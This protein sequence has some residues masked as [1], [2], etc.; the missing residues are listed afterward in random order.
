M[1]QLSRS[2]AGSTTGDGTH[3]ESKLRRS[4]PT[5]PAWFISVLLHSTLLVTLAL[6]IQAA[7]RGA[8]VDEPGRDVGLVLKKTTESGE[9]FYESDSKLPPSPD[10]SDSAASPSANPSQVVGDR[11]PVDVAAAL[12]QGKPLIGLGSTEAGALPGASGLTQGTGPTT[13][14]GKRGAARTKVYG[15]EGE[16]HKFVY[17]FDRSASMG[18]ERYSPLQAAKRE[19]KA[20]LDS[21]Q[22]QHQ[23]QIVFYNQEPRM[24]ALSGL[25]VAGVSQKLAFATDP[26]K[27][28]ARQFVDGIVADGA[29]EYVPA[30]ELGLGLAPDVLFFLT[31]AGTPLSE[32]QIQRITR[33]NRA[34][35]VL[36]AIEFG[37][38][39]PVGGENTLGRLSRENFGR[40]V[41]IDI[42]KLPT[43]P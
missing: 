18:N 30:L 10:Q 42:T 36:H 35:T 41:Y 40:Y 3:A 13:G 5:V 23:F 9:D 32:G 33:A 27:Q 39:P 7:P 31:D 21:L 20:S 14:V 6:T 34:G 8:A 37:E 4:W 1:S 11:P 15:L 25:P 29:T 22:P 19:L 2:S 28:A 12:P 24:F 16:G 17:V 38:G 43:G 26:N